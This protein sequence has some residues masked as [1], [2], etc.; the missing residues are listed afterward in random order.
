MPTVSRNQLKLW[1]KKGLKPTETQFAA[2]LDSYLHKEEDSF[3]LLSVILTGMVLTN[4]ADVVA[5]DTVI[6]GFGKIQRILNDVRAGWLQRN[7]AEAMTGDLDLGGYKIKN[8][9]DAV[10]NGE[11][12]TY[13]Q[14]IS[15]LDG[16]KYKPTPVDAASVSDDVVHNGEQTIDGVDLEDGDR[17]LDKDNADATQRGVW[18][19]VDGDDWYRAADCDEGPELVNAVVTVTGGTVN[20]GTGWLQ[21]EHDIEVDVTDLNWVPF[22]TGVPDATPTTKGKLKLYLDLLNNFTDGAPTQAA[23]NTALALKAPL[24]SPVLTG[25]PTAPT[26]AAADNSTKIATTAY[27]DAAAAAATIADATELVKGKAKLYDDVAGNNTDGAP[28]Q[29]SVNVALASKAPLASPALTGVPT[30]P[31]AAGGT[32]TTQLATTAFVKAALDSL[33]NA[34]PGALDTLD[35]LAAALGDD[36]NFAATITALIGTKAADADVVKLTGNQNVA[37]IKTF[38]S[39]PLTP[40]AAPTSDYEVANK[41][42]VDDSLLQDETTLAFIQSNY[43]MT[44]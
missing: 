29:N 19:V 13:G 31:T 6:Q 28:D 1:F 11:V 30:A 42:Y 32:N 15:A 34:A 17:F 39:F 27:A 2:W 44:R 20:A 40:S 12:V 9:I 8:V 24:A 22:G 26:Q 43:L 25:N 14:W 41:K 7:G 4:A 36:A 5:T 16:V 18:V 10:A 37:G 35:E 21:I 38:T 3:D 23:V 33:I